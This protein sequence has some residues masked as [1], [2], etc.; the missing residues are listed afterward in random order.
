MKILSLYRFESNSWLSLGIYIKLCAVVTHL[1]VGSHMNTLKTL[2]PKT[3]Y[4]QVSLC[5]SE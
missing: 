5:F 1:R 4:A 3:D 2:F